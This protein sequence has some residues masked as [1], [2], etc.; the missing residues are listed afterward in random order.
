VTVRFAADEN[1]N[2]KIVTGLQR[3]IEGLDIVRVQDAG[4]RTADDPAVLEWAAEQ[5]RVLLTHDAAT[6]PGF[7]LSRV[8]AHQ[9]MAGVFVV[10]ATLAIGDAI[11]ELVL[12][13]EA[14]LDGEWDGEVRYLP[15]R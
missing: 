11:D 6:M 13:A 7:A 12:I 8:P 14:S 4:L 10:P 1:F 5:G 15:L 9:P 3:R 2:R